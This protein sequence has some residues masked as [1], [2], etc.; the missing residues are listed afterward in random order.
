VRFDLVQLAV[1]S[2]DPLR[3]EAVLVVRFALVAEVQDE[4]VAVAFEIRHGWESNARQLTR[5][6]D[7]TPQ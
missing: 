2:V 3:A 1:N 7:P 6:T 4:Y 5:R